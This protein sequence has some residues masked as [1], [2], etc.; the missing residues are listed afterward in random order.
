MEIFKF[1]K[2][3]FDFVYLISGFCGG[4]NAKKI[5]CLDLVIQGDLME[6]LGFLLFVEIGCILKCIF[7]IVYNW[8]YL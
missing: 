7:L 5:L 1:K 3:K 8:N 2:Y 4:K 6:K